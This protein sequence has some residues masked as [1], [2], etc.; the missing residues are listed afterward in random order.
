MNIFLTLAVSFGLIL[1]QTSILPFLF[2]SSY[3]NVVTIYVIY[4]SLFSPFRQ[5]LLSVIISGI[6]LD[7]LSGGPFGLYVTVYFWLFVG[8][9]WVTRYLHS[10]NMFLLPI[11]IIVGV[12]LENLISISVALT[13]H[14]NLE[15][16]SFAIDLVKK[17][18]LW[19]LLA[20]PFLVLFV[21][22]V[23]QRWKQ[24]IQF[25]QERRSEYTT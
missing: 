2:T 25:V 10:Q 19:S 20:G 9:K 22:Q 12:L 21:S 8:I 16:T 14:R 7:S 4:L 1:F 11:F 3:I 24:W 6:F 5:G 17:Q 18:L 15:F 13:A 23:H